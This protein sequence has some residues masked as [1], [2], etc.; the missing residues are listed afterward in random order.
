MK[1][2]YYIINTYVPELD[3]PDAEL[4]AHWLEQ[5]DAAEDLGFDSLW[6]TEHH[7]RLFGGMLPNPQL[8][9]TAAAQ[10]TRRLRLGT[11]VTLL[12]MHNPIRIAED[13]AMLDLLSNGRVN[14]G[15]GRGMSSRE[16]AIFGEDW[17]SAQARLVEALEVLVRAWRDEVL[18]WDGN[19][20]HYQGLTVRPKPQQRPNPPI[21]VTAQKDPESFSMVG[22]RGFH[23]MT[24][25]WIFGNEAQRSRIE[26]YLGALREAGHSEENHE[27]FVM[28]PAYV[29]ESDEEA[30]ADVR[31]FWHTWRNF[32]VTELGLDPSKGAPYEERFRHLD[33][34]AMV[35]GNRAV[36]GG[37][38]TC[39]RHLQR[40]REIVQPTHVGLVFHFGGLSQKKLLKSMERFARHVLPA[41]KQMF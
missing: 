28:Y 41:F 18:N 33:Y 1:F 6:V 16:Y 10:R 23:L 5:I 2:G 19:Y 26:L 14:F 7:F 4:Y 21:Y 3:G 8:L 11:S 38:E 27:V 37:P 34:D 39:V 12:P 17:N 24:V 31:E 40:V 20:Y 29:G 36:F 13:F 15:A 30:R 22:R 32:A 9:L 25:P 35:A